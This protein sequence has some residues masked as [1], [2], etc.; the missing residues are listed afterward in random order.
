VTAAPA[1]DPALQGKAKEY[2]RVRR[3]LLLVDLA[4]KAA[5]TAAWLALGWAAAVEQWLA[6]L[7]NNPWLAVPLFAA[8]FFLSF[9]IFDVPLGYYSNYILAHRYG[10]ST[11]S[12]GGWVKDEVLGL[13]LGGSLGLPI[14]EAMYWLLRTAGAAWWLWAAGGYFALI[15][16][17]SLVAPVLILPLFNK[18]VPLGPEH[19]DLAERLRRLAARY[20][21]RVSGVFR[22][23]MSKRTRA[24]N[25][26][27]TGIGASRR[28]VLGDTLLSEFTPDEVE[29]V[30]AHELGH[31]V[32]NDIP[33][34]IA[35][36]GLLAVAALYLAAV[37]LAWGA[38]RLGF[39]GPD[40]I[41]A[42]PLLV[43]IFGA[44]GIL[45]LPIGNAFSRWREVRADEF[46][47]A[48]TQN[49]AAFA[50]AMTRLAN[51]NLAEADPERWVVVLLHSHPPIRSRLAMAAAWPAAQTGPS[52]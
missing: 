7:T 8:V 17:L 46:A 45:T 10:Q 26:A 39:S 38:T 43:L 28:I 16:V 47:L 15:V 3:R 40:D 52:T 5:W 30:I 22:F 20:Q 24:A 4:V 44:F 18:F 1:I 11:Q 32:H 31:H 19:A 33:M 12:L 14:I 42:L 50:G 9:E 27:L 36:S 23:D 29:T 2:A 13:I 49:P 41:G 21:T 35:F 51:Q 48:A 34:G 25:A 6:R 37:G